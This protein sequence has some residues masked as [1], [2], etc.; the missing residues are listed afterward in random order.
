[1]R[2]MLEGSRKSKSS[3]RSRCRINEQ[4]CYPNTPNVLVGPAFLGK[5]KQRR[6]VS[7]LQGVVLLFRGEPSGTDE[8]TRLVKY[9][10]QSM[11]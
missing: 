9:V 8:G 2:G 4:D 5:T 6:P 10:R 3:W 1:M 7:L 11:N